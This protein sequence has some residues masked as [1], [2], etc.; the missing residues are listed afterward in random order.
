M[1]A[2]AARP[3]PAVSSENTCMTKQR[4]HDQ[5]ECQHPLCLALDEAAFLQHP[6]GKLG[7]LQCKIYHLLG[8]R[9]AGCREVLSEDP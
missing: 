2:K 9:I 7:S 5:H 8:W 4:M 6:H 3:R 1:R